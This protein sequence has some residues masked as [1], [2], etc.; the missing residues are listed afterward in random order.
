MTPSDHKPRVVMLVGNFVEGDSRVQKEARYAAAAGWDTYLVGRSPSGRREE[1]AL[2]G[3]TVVR[4]AETMTATRY[5]ASHPHRRGVRGLVAYRSAELSRTRHQRQRLR[6]RDLGADRELLARRVTDGAGALEAL[7]TRLVLRLRVLSVRLRGR[8]VAVRKQAFDRNYAAAAGG[9]PSS[10]L[11]RLL[12]RRGSEAA[13]WAAQPR[14]ADFEDSFGRMAD[15]LMP[16]VLHANDAEM[17]GVAVRAAVRAR[18]AGRRVAVVYDSHEYTAGDI[19]PEDVTWAP[20][21]TAQEAKYIPM[22][23]A[24]VTAVDNFADKLVEHHGLAVRPTVVRNMPE[25]ATFSVPGGRGPGVRGRLGLGPEATLLVYPGSV[26]PIRGLDTAVRALPQLPEAHLALLVGSRAGHVAELAE[27]AARLGVAEQFHVLDY[28]PVEELTDFIASA[29]AGVDTLRRIPTQELTITTKYWSYIGA[30][31]PVV[32]SDVKAAGELTRRLRNGEVFEVDD[33]DG[34][35]RAV[36][37]VAADRERYAA[38]YTDE[39]LAAHSW[40]GQ[41]PALLE[42]YERVSGLR[43]EPGGARSEGSDDGD[44]SEADEGGESGGRVPTSRP[45]PAEAA[46]SV[47]RG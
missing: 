35:A 32:V 11:E 18:V 10:A 17:L 16:D 20:V 4:A 26:T 30:R 15:E 46:E 27:L 21:I 37:K 13:A 47:A 39:M 34:L 36:R 40:E 14:L 25:A 8:W 24:V 6:Q 9:G 41:V 43:P 38:V 44:D 29:T 45:D 5:R 2:G 1:Y 42:V 33:V 3:A 31:L 19:R 28:V 23:D 7:G 22:A 12:V